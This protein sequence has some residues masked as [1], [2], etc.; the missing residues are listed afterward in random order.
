MRSG[1]EGG[2]CPHCKA[3]VPKNHGRVCV[4]CGGSLQK[5][6]LS[7]GCLTSKP[8]I[9]IAVGLPLWLAGGEETSAEEVGATP[10]VASV[11]ATEHTT[12]QA[13]CDA[14]SDPPP[15]VPAGIAAPR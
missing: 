8:I 4:E 2:R 9:L 14:D 7:I 15:A 11:P 1:V 12:A 5:R 6:Y 13:T 3:D 10:P